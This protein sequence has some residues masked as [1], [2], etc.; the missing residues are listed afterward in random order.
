MSKSLRTIAIFLMVALPWPVLA[1]DSAVPAVQPPVVTG[2]AVQPAADVPALV[3]SDDG[4]GWIIIDGNNIFVY[5]LPGANLRK[6]EAR[7]RTRYVPLSSEYKVLLADPAYPVESR[8]SA[9]LHIILARVQA[10][11]GMNPV[12]A[13]IDVKVFRTRQDLGQEVFK[14]LQQRKDFKSFYIHQFRGIYTSEQDILDSVIAH[15]MS[16]AVIDHYF[17]VLPPSQ[18]AELLATYVDEHLERD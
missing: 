4:R 15:E 17:S 14:I 12:I 13:R 8:I 3:P 9:R 18:V 2:G 7:L 10:I 1:Q 11:L 5:Y 6:M 16:H